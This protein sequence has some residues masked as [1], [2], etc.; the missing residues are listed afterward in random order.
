MP[1]ILTMTLPT[2]SDVIHGVTL[3]VRIILAHFWHLIFR[4]LN[5]MIKTYMHTPVIDFLMPTGQCPFLSLKHCLSEH[6]TYGR[7]LMSQNVMK[8]TRLPSP[9]NF[10]SCI[11]KDNRLSPPP[12]DYPQ[13]CK[14]E[15]WKTSVQLFLTTYLIKLEI[16]IWK[17]PRIW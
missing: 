2:M 17:W 3:V 10:R 1:Y 8:G 7:D 11:I 4:C 6:E 15:T 14:F 5:H 9:S 12:A 16:I 13:T